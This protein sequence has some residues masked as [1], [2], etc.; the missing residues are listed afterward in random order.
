M[1]V[2][3]IISI[4]V[5]I[6]K[7]EAYLQRCIDSVLAQNFTDWEM[8]LVDDGSPDRC[9][10]ICDEYASK[11]N[12]IRVIHKKNGGL[13]S[14]RQ[15]GFVQAKGEYIMH[16]DSDDW[17][18]P[19]ALTT[20]CNYAIEGDYDI[21]RG[22]NRRVYDDGHFT[23]EG[24]DLPKGETIGNVNY[25]SKFLKGE[26]PTYLW[27]AIYKRTLFSKELFDPIIGIST[28]E[29]WLTNI[30][31]YKKVNKVLFV[32]DIVYCYYINSQSIMQTK[33]CSNGYG[34]KCHKILSKFIEDAPEEVKLLHKL[35]FIRG[36][37][38]GQFVPELYFCERFY[39]YAKSEMKD[40]YIRNTIYSTLSSRYLRFFDYPQLYK[41][42]TGLFRILFLVVKQK[43]KKKSILK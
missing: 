38:T 4:I 11:D 24:L 32:D 9:P 5:P 14:A 15:A 33:V 6:Y 29:D 20:L 7:V 10:Q 2:N 43:G 35:N 16:L 34:E 18:M 19:N 27:G 41:M 39:D 25:I 13:V 22:C 36:C 23:L 30:G 28:S 37:I 21:V 31:I 17:L 8:I 40:P 42:Y 12:R 3:L 1:T 26:I